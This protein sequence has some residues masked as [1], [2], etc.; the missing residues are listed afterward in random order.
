MGDGVAVSGSETRAT[1]L[2]VILN[3]AA[4][5]V[6]ASGIHELLEHHIE[7]GDGSCEVH[8]TCDQDD[9]AALAR[10]AS[11]RGCDV[12][13]AAG[14]DGTVSAVADG[15]VGRPT[16]LG[17]LPLG[18]A[19]VLAQEL[20]IP[21]DLESAVAL[22][23]G[24]HRVTRV[25]AMQVRDRYALTQVGVGIDALMIRDTTTE[26]KQRFGNLAYIWTA[27][28]RLIGYQPGRFRLVVDGAEHRTGA[29]QIVLANSRTMGRPPF[30]WGPGIHPDD[31]QIAVCIIRARTG[32]D[33]L[34]VTWHFLRKQERHSPHIRYLK[35]TR[36]VRVESSR[37][38]P[39]QADGEIIGQTPVEVT[40]VPGAIGV[41]VPVEAVPPRD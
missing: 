21:L 14:G 37:E 31:G 2:F 12:V 26:T 30:R 19:N 5:S 40:V 7:C 25:D 23:A 13:V 20:G 10:A 38:L 6:A 11:E 3:P 9:P 34:S 28:R 24:P 29:V 39:V 1:R 17:I 32:W 41:V 33:Y 15:L 27:C 16:A 35:A 18:T 8:E 22:L 4:G 36:E